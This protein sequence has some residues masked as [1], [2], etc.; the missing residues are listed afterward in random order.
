MVIIM[1]KKIIFI[2]V[3]GTLVGMQDNRQIIPES[4]ISAIQKARAKG[5]LV[6]LCTGRSKAELDNQIMSIGFDGIIGAAGGFIE[7]NNE[8]IF[9][10]PLPKEDILSITSYFHEHDIQYYLESNM[11]LFVTYGFNKIMRQLFGESQDTNEFFIQCQDILDADLS[12]VNKISFISP[13]LS[14]EEIASH[15]Q[16]AYQLVKASWADERITAGEISNPGINKATAIHYLTDY[17]QLDLENTYGIGDS[18]ND[19]E[20]FECVK[21]SIAMGNSMHGVKDKAE[22]VTKDIFEDG[23][24]YALKHYG[25][26]E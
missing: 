22:F 16:D 11:G 21:H 2:D 4:A 6:Y 1:D 24:E 8:M 20:M 25:L 26:I 10:Q 14:Y 3:D 15:F 9:H 13:I 5:H 7:E 18:M 17:L 19:V 12:E 23:I